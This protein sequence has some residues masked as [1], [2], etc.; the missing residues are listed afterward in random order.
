[1][2]ETNPWMTVKEAKAWV[3]CGESCIYKAIKEGKLKAVKVG[4]AF[5]IHREWLE[6]WMHAQA[7]VVNPQAPGRDIPYD[8]TPRAKH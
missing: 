1:M 6:A 7:T 2:T 4:L 3:R 8:P 5:R